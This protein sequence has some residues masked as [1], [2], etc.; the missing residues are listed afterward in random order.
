MRS[1]KR[2]LERQRSALS[3]A[4]KALGAERSTDHRREVIKDPYGAASITHDDE[5]NVT[6]A[7][8]RARQL[9]EVNRALDDIDA[10]RYGVCRECGE[11]IAEARLNAIP[12][13]R[14]CITCKEK[15]GA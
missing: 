14:L 15:Q 3:S 10:G 2:D 1:I 5:I 4:I 7:D 8:H 12:W 6:V 9:E 13:S 11:P